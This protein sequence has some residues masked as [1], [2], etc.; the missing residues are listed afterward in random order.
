ML[1]YY[2][3]SSLY[4]NAALNISANMEIISANMEVSFQGSPK[5]PG[6][7]TRPWVLRVVLH[8]FVALP[9]APTIRLAW[10]YRKMVLGLFGMAKSPQNL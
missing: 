9:P 4:N 7:T 1:S 10:L 3:K 6:L 2:T 8:N 5:R